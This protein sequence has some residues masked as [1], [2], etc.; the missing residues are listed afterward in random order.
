M[1]E[2]RADTLAALKRSSLFRGLSPRSFEI[3]ADMALW[4]RFSKGEQIFWQGQPCPGVFCVV[5]GRVRVFKVAP[6][7]KDHVLHFA[8]P[9]STFAE[10]AVMGSFP[11]P[12]NA[13]A[14]DDSL[15]V[16]LP[17]APFQE[18]LR[19]H[20]ELCLGLLQGMAGWV[21]QLVGL[22]E[23]VVLRDASGRLAR[24]LLE[25]ADAE[26]EEW[27]QLRILKKDLASHLNLTSETLS[28]TLRRLADAGL[29]DLGEGQRIRLL[30]RDAL[31]EVASG[32]LPSEF[33]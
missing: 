1:T 23:D 4:K 7:G 30:Q 24:H 5:T 19:S 6:S 9:G 12:A 15:C 17:T 31:R 26:G 11:T 18:A 3:L 10:I 14:I 25:A 20:H 33:D 13:E 22:L 8:E 27:F 16:L 2:R 28:R 21:R 29:I 32:L